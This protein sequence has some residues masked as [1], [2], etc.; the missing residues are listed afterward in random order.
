[1]VKQV[2]QEHYNSEDFQKWWERHPWRAVNVNGQI[3]FHRNILLVL[4]LVFLTVTG[5]LYVVS[6]DIDNWKKY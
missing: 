5:L 4:I 6:V 2:T 3:C 1:M